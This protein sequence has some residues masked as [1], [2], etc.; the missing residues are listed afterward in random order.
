MIR[1]SFLLVLFA[2]LSLAA[3]SDIPDL[4]RTI[5]ASELQG[6]Y[7]ALVPQSEILARGQKAQIAEGD[8]AALNARAAALRAR[9][10]RLRQIQ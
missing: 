3:C 2:L 4:G 8:D 10:A 1:T 7:P 5:P 6:D 9:A